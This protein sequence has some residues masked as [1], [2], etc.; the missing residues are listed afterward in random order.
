MNFGG[1]LLLAIPLLVGC[2]SA[3]PGRYRLDLANADPATA[4]PA[5]ADAHFA[6]S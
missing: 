5:L 1:F 3:P 6:G 4:L 2:S